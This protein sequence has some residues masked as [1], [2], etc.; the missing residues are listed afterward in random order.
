MIL[1]RILATDEMRMPPEGEGETLKLDEVAVL[2]AWIDVGAGDL[3]SRHPRRILGALGVSTTPAAR[4]PLDG[5]PVVG[6]QSDRRPRGGR[7]R[8]VESPIGSS[9]GEACLVAS[10]LPRLDRPAP[11]APGV[12]RLH[13]RSQHRGP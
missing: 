12:A 5:S 11:L 13:V 8:G 2:N 10:G 7:A 3:R 4:G 9:G 1:D 6:S